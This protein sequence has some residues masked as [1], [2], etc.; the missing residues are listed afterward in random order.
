MSV[1]HRSAEFAEMYASMQQDLR[2]LMQIPSNYKILFMHGGGSSQFSMVP[3]NLL[4]NNTSA[5]YVDTGHW[6]KKA[7]KE[8]NRYCNVKVIAKGKSAALDLDWKYNKDSAYIH[9]TPNETIEGIEFSDIAGGF[10]IPVVADFS[11]SILSAPIDVKKYGLIYAGAQK[12]IG[13]AGMVIVIVREDLLGKVSRYAPLP[14][15][16]KQHVEKGSMLNTPPTFSWYVAHRV[17]AWLKRQGGI[18]SIHKINLAKAKLLYDF[19]DS[20]EFYSNKINKECRSIMNVPFFLADEGLSEK[21]ITEAKKHGLHGLKG[22]RSSGGMR[23]SI[24]NAM[25]L[26]GV[27]ALVEF[28]ESFQTSLIRHA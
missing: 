27:K 11:S 14:Y 9:C 8:A 20:S 23:A 1:S 3:L 24:Y 22:H 17:F 4:G 6:S 13:P 19:I 10:S 7:I 28:M 26:D 5:D 12:N 25:S 15:D 21:F 2:D 16:Y 18:E